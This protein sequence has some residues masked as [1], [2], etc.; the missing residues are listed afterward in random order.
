MN[1]LECQFL[2]NFSTTWD[3]HPM[4][5]NTI[6]CL[7]GP[8]WS[9]VQFRSARMHVQTLRT[10][11]KFGS[12]K[13]PASGSLPIH[14]SC[15][16]FWSSLRQKGGVV[17]PFP[18][19][20]KNMSSLHPPKFFGMV[21]VTSCFPWFQ[22]RQPSLPPGL[23]PRFWPHPFDHSQDSMS[24]TLIHAGDLDNDDSS[25]WGAS[26]IC[27]W[28]YHPTQKGAGGNVSFLQ[29]VEQFPRGRNCCA[30]FWVFHRQCHHFSYSPPTYPGKHHHCLVDWL[31]HHVVL[32][33]WTNSKKKPLIH[34]KKPCPHTKNP[35]PDPIDWS[36]QHEA[37]PVSDIRSNCFG[38][39]YQ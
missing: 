36:F 8:L 35:H 38:K 9:S 31:Y 10:S 13:N 1:G 28:Y 15:Y 26:W 34:I 33:I 19:S 14:S 6:C 30:T 4:S 25:G 17:V 23:L 20:K 37:T 32:L 39:W 18:P 7:Y 27:F 2:T 16:W 3:D 22:P 5:K 21:L 24:Q 29:N 12:S 11:G